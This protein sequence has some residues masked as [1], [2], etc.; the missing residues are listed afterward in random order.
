VTQSGKNRGSDR[1][2]AVDAKRDPIPP[3][4]DGRRSRG[5]AG[6]TDEEE[7]SD[8]RRRYR[9]YGIEPISPDPCIGALIAPAEQVLASHRWVALDRRQGSTE[10]QASTPMRGDLYVTTARLVHVGRHVVTVELDDIEDAALV[11]DRVLLVTHGGIG[12]TLETD[13]PQLLR[14]QLAAARAARTGP[15]RPPGRSQ[16]A[17]R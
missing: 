10:A 12:I 7:A 1:G 9:R 8:A 3:D 17:A 16:G 5:L 13:R 2:A 6:P 4:L 11:G 14:V 15:T